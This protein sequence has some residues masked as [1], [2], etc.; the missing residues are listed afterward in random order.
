M[1]V[2]SRHRQGKIPA[3][4]T[5]LQAASAMRWHARGLG[6]APSLGDPPGDQG[7]VG[8]GQPE[9]L[10]GLAGERFV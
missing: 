5:K 7:L 9:E 6:P 4:G 3:V 10:G 8:A 2:S 1:T